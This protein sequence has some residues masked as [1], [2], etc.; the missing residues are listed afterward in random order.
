MLFYF[1]MLPY[2]FYWL[3]MCVLFLLSQ[4]LFV[5]LLKLLYFKLLLKLQKGVSGWFS[6]KESIC[7]TG[8]TKDTGS[9]PESG[10]S[11]GGGHGNPLQYSCLE[12]PLDR[13]AWQGNHRVAK[14]QTRLKRRNTVSPKKWG[15]TALKS[16][17][18]SEREPFQYKPHQ[19]SLNSNLIRRA[20]SSTKDAKSR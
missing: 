2:H 17:I 12:N 6:D 7:N 18:M 10:R 5:C 3:S 13:G 14:S 1:I 15:A 4:A 11:P 16:R 8:D 9:I 20:L 19:N